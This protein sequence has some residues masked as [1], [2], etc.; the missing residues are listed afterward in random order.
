MALP[1]RG[2]SQLPGRFN[3][4]LTTRDI[5][6]ILVAKDIEFDIVVVNEVE[7]EVQEPC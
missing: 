1:V 7:H 3:C 2:S 6:D 4:P 5:C